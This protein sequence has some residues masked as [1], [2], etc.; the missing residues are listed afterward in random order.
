MHTLQALEGPSAPYLNE[1]Q[2]PNYQP[3]IPTVLAGNFQIVPGA[4]RLPSAA[5]AQSLPRRRTPVHAAEGRTTASLAADFRSGVVGSMVTLS[6]HGFA[7]HADIAI[8]WETVVG[9]DIT[10]SGWATQL[11]PLASAASDADGRFSVRV[12]TPEDLGGDHRIVARQRGQPAT[13]VAT[14]YTLTPSISEIAPARVRPGEQITVH[15]NGAGWSETGN[16]YTVVV[17]NAYFGYACGFFSQ[18]DVTMRIHAPGASGWHFVD[19]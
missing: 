17:D 19:L 1:Q 6:G 12:R 3:L 16:I 14:S 7:P 13:A 11:R 15:V 5:N 10:G 2:S 9:N 8:A 18:G 4:P